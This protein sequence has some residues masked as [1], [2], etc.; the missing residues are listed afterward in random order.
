[1]DKC[2]WIGWAK[3]TKSKKEGGLGFR[4]LHIFILAMLTRQGW[5]LL[6]EPDTLCAQVLK[7]RY[8]PDC[9]VPDAVAKTEMSY[10]WRNILKGIKLLKEVIVRRIGS[11]ENVKI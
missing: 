10:T 2:H 5:R 1:M 8:Y 3:L 7:A 11:G 9:L 4:E 6:Q